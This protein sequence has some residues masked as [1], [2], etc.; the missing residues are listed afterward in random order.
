[1]HRRIELFEIR[2]YQVMTAAILSWLSNSLSVVLIVV[3]IFY[4]YAKYKL[5]Y[6]KRRGVPSPPTHFIFGNFKDAVFFKTSPPQIMA[7]I[8]E[9][10]G[11]DTPFVGFHIFH[12]P[13]L[14]VKDPDLI[15]TIL[16]KDFEAFPNRHFAKHA[17]R[18]IP[19]SQNLFSMNNPK[20]KYVRS[21]ITPTLTSVKLKKMVPLMIETAREM[22]K[23]IDSHP[24]DSHSRKAMK[25]R[26]TSSKY[27]TDIISSLAFGIQTNSFLHP[28]PEF[29]TRGRKLFDIT[30][31]RT[32]SLF[33]MF[34][35]SELSDMLRTSMLGESEKFFRDIFWA[36][37]HARE[38]SGK[39]RGDLIDSLIQLKNAEQVSDFEFS[40][41]H[42][43]AQSAIFFVA[44]HETSSLTMAF[45][46]F[47]LAKNPEIQKRARQDVRY[48]LK[49]HG[50]TQEAFQEMKY[51]NQVISE[52]LRMYPP[53]PIIDRVAERDYKIPGS[54]L[55]IEKGTPVYVPLLGL[56]YNPKYHPEPWK[57]D[58][59][60]FS[61]E[62]KKSLVPMTYMPFGEGPRYCVGQ[63][64]GQLQSLIGLG[65]ILSEY[66]ISLNP[67]I[68]TVVSPK[69]IFLAPSND[70][71][72]I[73][74][75]DTPNVSN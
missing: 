9:Q 66:E 21:K 73:L 53:A 12:R 54:D 38:E 29:R 32:L 63:R 15:R 1:M 37:V 43:F 59:D 49:K 48:Q 40:G 28:E 3:G 52:T 72:L 71:N 51:L 24:A 74:K 17:K 14:I 20:W 57:F 6:W 70:I 11:E 44:G 7:K 16:I 26:D 13:C 25:M 58:P 30:L 67:D 56:H 65:M 31:R 33:V 39:H 36:S 5:N 42:L 68:D 22:L 46:L 34:F 2:L 35:F 18:D 75:K 8:Q 45:T 41:D 69:S 60:R 47:E 55:V 62:R 27:T 61:D 64:I 19:G 4:A 10:A 23:Y 50:V